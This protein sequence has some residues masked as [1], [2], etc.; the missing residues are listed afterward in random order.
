MKNLQDYITETEQWVVSPSVGDDFA[1]NI[2]EECLLESYI[3]E[4]TDNEL[5]IQADDEMLQIL[6]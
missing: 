4:A 2:R 6:G 5:M 1:I 3:I